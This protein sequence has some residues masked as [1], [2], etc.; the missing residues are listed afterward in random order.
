VFDR[1]PK[2]RFPN[3]FVQFR[4]GKAKQ[5]PLEAEILA[6]A[7]LAVETR[8][9]KY[10]TDFGTYFPGLADGIEATHGSATAARGHHRCEDTE[11]SGF[12]RTVR[13]QQPYQTGLRHLKG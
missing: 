1:Q 7:Q 6:Y 13:A 12:A 2:G 5:I 10:D 3:A 4:T 11:K 9:L 8:F